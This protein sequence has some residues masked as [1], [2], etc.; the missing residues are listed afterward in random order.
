MLK[1]WGGFPLSPNTLFFHPGCPFLLRGPHTPQSKVSSPTRPP[2]RVIAFP[3]IHLLSTT[4]RGWDP[5]SVLSPYQ[6]VP[7]S[8]WGPPST[9]GPLSLLDAPFL[10]G[11]PFSPF[12]LSQVP[13]SPSPS[14]LASYS[15][16]GHS[17]HTLPSSSRHS[18]LPHSAA[19]FPYVP[20]SLPRHPSLFQCPFLSPR[21]VLP[22]WIWGDGSSSRKGEGHCLL[23]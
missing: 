13:S 19:S 2:T 3:P 12:L 7:F 18:L 17:P 6:E 4:S 8:S 10:S 9:Q 5:P 22:S 20:L 15:P 14:L 16:L 1:E 21:C 11:V 23:E